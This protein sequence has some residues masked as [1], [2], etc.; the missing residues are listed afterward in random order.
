M[1]QRL[2]LIDWLEFTVPDTDP[3]PILYYLGFDGDLTSLK[4]G[5]GYSASFQHSCGARIYYDGREDMGVHVRFSG[6]AIRQ[7]SGSVYNIPLAARACRATYTRVDLA[8]DLKDDDFTIDRLYDKHKKG[9]LSMLWQQVSRTESTTRAG[10]L[11]GKTLYIGS[12]T[13]N[14]FLRFYDKFLESKQADFAGVERLEIEYKKDAAD[15]IGKALEKGDM[16]QDLLL[17]TLKKYLQ[18]KERKVGKNRSRWPPCPIYADLI[19]SADK[20][21]LTYPDEPL[22]IAKA[23]EIYWKQ[24]AGLAHTIAAYDGDTEFLEA[25]RSG[26]GYRLSAKHRALLESKRRNEQNN[27][28]E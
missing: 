12:R 25:C 10:E 20:I 8:L 16:P 17:S 1:E 18:V 11:S 6:G 23:K 26:A 9:L 28:H 13:S 19:G 22:T 21:K 4:G 24:S 15:I 27:G 14:V 2:S 7:Y 5:L 3:S